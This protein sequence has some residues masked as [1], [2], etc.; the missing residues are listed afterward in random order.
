M[1]VTL[2]KVIIVVILA[3]VFPA[4][5]PVHAQEFRGSW[6]CLSVDF[7]VPVRGMVRDPANSAKFDHS[8]QGTSWTDGIANLSVGWAPIMVTPT[9]GLGLAIRA[10]AALALGDNGK[11]DK[12]S[13]LMSY[14]GYKVK[15][16]ELHFLYLGTWVAASP[17]IASRWRLHP[18]V[19]FN[20]SAGPTFWRYLSMEYKESHYKDNFLDD[21]AGF[22]FSAMA[23]LSIQWFYLEAGI[24]GPDGFFGL[25]FSI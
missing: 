18:G 25:G 6:I 24:S 7:G 22:S 8:G 16:G 9:M 14:L 21:A 19:Y 13:S 4:I 11:V 17:M 2:A 15:E 23:Q 1:R 10:S 5:M 20:I 3:L 12:Y